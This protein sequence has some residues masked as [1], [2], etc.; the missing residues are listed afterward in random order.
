MAQLRWFFV[1]ND[2]HRTVPY[3]CGYCE[4]DV[5]AN[6]TCILQEYT[7]RSPRDW[8]ATGQ[9]AIAC[10]HCHKWS[11]MTNDSV[12]PLPRFGR[13]IEHLPTDVGSIYEEA[14]ASMGAGAPTAAV[15]CCRKIIMNLAVEEGATPGL[16]FVEYLDDLRKKGHIPPRW[17]GWVESIRKAGNEATH[18]VE[19]Q[20]LDEARRTMDFTAMLLAAHYEGPGRLNMLEPSVETERDRTK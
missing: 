2:A 1:E 19:P 12:E 18:E 3:R 7:P 9:F 4:R 17:Q 11:N 13:E 8:V 10:P 20:T 5:S 14:R 6:T 16:K 15:M